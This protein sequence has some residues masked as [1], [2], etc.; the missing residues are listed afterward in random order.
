MASPVAVR[1]PLTSRTVNTQFFESKT[2]VVGQK[3]SHAQI[4]G[5]QEN[6][7]THI[8]G[9]FKSPRT[10][11]VKTAPQFKQPLP[12]VE[13]KARQRQQTNDPA[14]QEPDKDMQQWRRSMKVT[15]SRSTFYFDGVEE[16]FKEQATRWI[17]RLGGVVPD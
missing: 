17:V 16:T 2:S 8:F 5:G 9:A 15:F 12:R 6:L 4:T 1:Q 3:R 7:Q 10:V 13:T 14:Q 11:K